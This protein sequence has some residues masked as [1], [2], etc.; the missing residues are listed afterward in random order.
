[1]SIALSLVTLCSIKPESVATTTHPGFYI[2]IKGV[3]NLVYAAFNMKS[4][5]F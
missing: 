3:H 4:V 1:M 2:Y 5:F